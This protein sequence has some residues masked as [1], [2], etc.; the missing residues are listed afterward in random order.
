MK[1][2]LVLSPMQV[3]LVAAGVTAGLTALF[4]Q[5]TAS[6]VLSF[7]QFLLALAAFVYLPGKVLL[8]LS[9]LSL[10]PLERFTF[11]L[12][13]GIIGASVAYWLA[14]FLS[15]P[16]LV[17]LWPEAAG[18]IFCYR[19]GRGWREMRGW[20]LVLD[21]SH[22]L[23]LG[24]VVIAC[25]PLAFLPYYFRN[26]ARLPDG[27]MSYCPWQDIPL[28]L[29]I[30]NELTH[31]VPP[32]VPF[33]A[34]RG[35]S[36][37]YAMD[38]PAALFSKIAGLNT[39]DLT[40]RFLPTFFL[41]LAALTLF[42][43]SRA[44]LQ[45]GR[46]AALTVFLVLLGEDFSFIPGWFIGR[47]HPLSS[48]WWS[49]D[50]FLMPT[51]F[52]LY[53]LNPILPALAVLFGGLFCLLKYFREGGRG[54]LVL[55][56]F[57]FAAALEYKVFPSVQLLMS[58][59]LAS[60]V[61]L[62]RFRDLRLLKVTVLTS[63]MMLPLLWFMWRAN[64]NATRQV[65]RIY[66][67]RI[68]ASLRGL[69]W[70]ATTWGRA[71]TDL[72]LGRGFSGTGLAALLLI[73]LPVY[74]I[75]SLGLRVL[76]LP[77]LGKQL[78]CPTSSSSLRFVLA[79]FVTIGAMLSLT[80]TLVVADL[81]LE[82]QYNNATW[83]F[84]QSKHL[85]WFFVVELLLTL[86]ALRTGFPRLA[87]AGLVVLLA[88]PSTV[89]FFRHMTKVLPIETVPAQEVELVNFLG[90]HCRSGEVILMHRD[91]RAPITSLVRCRLPLLPHLF[92]SSFLP[93]DELTRRNADCQAFWASFANAEL[94]ADVLDRYQVR[95]V[96]LEGGPGFGSVGVSL[97]QQTGAATVGPA[98]LFDNGVFRVY[99][100]HQRKP[101]RPI[102][103]KGTLTGS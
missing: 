66:P 49:V 25:L 58:L 37:H 2:R 16:S 38:L 70:E 65:L 62:A 82:G 95:Y 26:M 5:W 51:T 10:L 86:P 83:F 52:S 28:H 31:T 57:Q 20:R 40:V 17:Y 45:S 11:S 27:G 91:T 53:S 96:V 3:V 68:P 33:A 56:C 15:I 102:E 72:L 98:P 48:G 32:Q 60:L 99:E 19:S 18:L 29:S 7:P 30:S 44:W 75:G 12:L 54:W 8:D 41:V 50:Y 6:S 23:L 77:S 97:S 87:V 76:A 69:G 22:L 1:P 61:Y 80:C 4:G 43:F 84:V 89:Q 93:A 59:G 24:V 64:E 74:G 79:V 36:Y 90:C 92:I 78:V 88:V 46:G 94:R 39:L 67:D 47:A 34:G 71:V 42:C 73:V 85:M 35:L 21:D 103:T 81:P 13:L 100:V 55:A 9:R 63:A 101:A 14:T